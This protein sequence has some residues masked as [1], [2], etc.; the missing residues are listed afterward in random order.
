LLNYHEL[1][2]E[3]LDYV[4][5]GA[6]DEVGNGE[7]LYVQIDHHPI[8]VFS[9]AGQLFAI[10][11]RCSHDGNPLGDGELEDHSIICPRHGA[12]FDIRSGKVLSMPAYE[13]IPAYPVRVVSGQIEVGIPLEP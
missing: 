6:A 3:K 8:V 12:R 4:A 10:Q 5:I 9:I 11:D 2:S 1:E 13:D 7:R